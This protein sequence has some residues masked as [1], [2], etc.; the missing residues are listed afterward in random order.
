[1]ETSPP[2]T[3]EKTQTLTTSD[4]T[5]P[6]ETSEPQPT[7]YVILPELKCNTPW[8]YFI[9]TMVFYMGMLLSYIYAAMYMGTYT[10]LA[11]NIFETS[12]K[13]QK[14]FE[15]YINVIVLDTLNQ[16]TMGGSES[17]T[18]KYPSSGESIRKEGNTTIFD[19]M[20]ENINRVI[21]NIFYVRGNKMTFSA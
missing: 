12:E 2:P 20:R 17:F 21:T 14:R 19:K 8:V 18:V 7:K 15:E 16:P 4:E 10:P 5:P 13:A 6:T 1:M 3:L 11:G 9:I